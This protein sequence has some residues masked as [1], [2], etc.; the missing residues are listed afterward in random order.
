LNREISQRREQLAVG[1]RQ[2]ALTENLK[3]GI[4]NEAYVRDSYKCQPTA[5]FVSQRM[6]AVAFFLN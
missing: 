3:S 6:R 1:R 4:W 5:Q 2:G